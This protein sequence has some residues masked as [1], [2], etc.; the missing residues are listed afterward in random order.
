[1][2]TSG[3]DPDHLVRAAKKYGLKTEEMQPMTLTE[4]RGTVTE[5][6]PVI[7]M[8]QAWG[9]RKTY[10]DDWKHGHWVVAIGWDKAGVYFEDPW[11]LGARGYLTHAELDDRWHDVGKHN[12]HV[13][14]YGLAVWHREETPK[15]RK[16]RLA[17]R[18]P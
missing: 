3:A 15:G 10:K 1:M 13:P 6:R 9:N 7:C 18:I 2:P 11:I 12:R 17:R 16:I 8:L 4:L 5:G 14:R